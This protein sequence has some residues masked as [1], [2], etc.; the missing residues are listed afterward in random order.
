MSIPS[1]T[2]TILATGVLAVA[3]V[4]VSVPPVMATPPTPAVDSPTDQQA[5]EFRVA[6][7]A[8]Q[9][10][11]YVTRLEA[12]YGFHTTATDYTLT[13]GVP[14]RNKTIQA[15]VASDPFLGGA[16]VHETYYRDGVVASQHRYGSVER[17]TGNGPRPLTGWFTVNRADAGVDPGAADARVMARIPD[18]V[19]YV[20]GP[21][22]GET[23]NMFLPEQIAERLHD[24]GAVPW[25]ATDPLALCGWDDEYYST[26]CTGTV[27]DDTV[28]GGREW[29]FDVTT[30]RGG[31]PDRVYTVQARSDSNGFLTWKSTT[32]TPAG[33][34]ITWRTIT[35]A[36]HVGQLPKLPA[37]P[38]LTRD[39]TLS[40]KAFTQL[41][42]EVVVG[43]LVRNF[44]KTMRAELAR[45][46]A[47]L[48]SRTLARAVDRVN[49][50]DPSWWSP[51]AAYSA[52]NNSM[53]WGRDLDG[54]Y[55]VGT[56]VS[57]GLTGVDLDAVIGVAGGQ[58]QVRYDTEPLR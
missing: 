3:M 14:R 34:N 32:T 57:D 23:A 45:M 42:A 50:R 20:S 31:Q 40:S 26:D 56:S 22:P 39:T 54:R 24:D 21:V 9:A 58:F 35:R 38:R 10:A 55:R 33:G 2:W 51:D 52:W 8:L 1:R 43:I 7:D 48:M 47:P 5:E 4:A 15:W 13:D 6:W 41:V 37:G 11:A 28:T 16:A 19:R 53:G 46:N 18:R 25:N 17:G 30:T 27:T 12:R 36:H 49:A 29:Q 44:K